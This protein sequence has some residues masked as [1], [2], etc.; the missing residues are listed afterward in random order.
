MAPP[1]V[2]SE[3]TRRDHGQAERMQLPEDALQVAA[4]G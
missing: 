1:D 4:R 2:E 3:R